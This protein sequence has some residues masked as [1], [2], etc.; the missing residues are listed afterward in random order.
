MVTFHR[1]ADQEV[2]SLRDVDLFAGC[3]RDELR[4]IGS[5]TT[6][7]EV[8]PGTVLIQ[9][10]K[11]GREFFA[12]IKGTAT[13]SRDGLWLTEFGPG[14]FFGELALLDRGLRTATVTADTQMS[15]FVFSRTEFSS[16]PGLAP[17]VARKMAV[18]LTRRIRRTSELLEQ[19]SV[20]APS[21]RPIVQRRATSA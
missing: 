16:I 1:R 13:A 11:V 14:S 18:E 17:S 19:E 2:A 20:C 4:R 6:S 7:L 9:E 5:L 8:K 21:L 10:G 15:L 12:V 3:N